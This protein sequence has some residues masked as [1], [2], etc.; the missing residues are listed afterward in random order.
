MLSIPN[1][2]G[3]SGPVKCSAYMCLPGGMGSHIPRQGHAEHPARKVTP[4]K[5]PTATG[6]LQCS[7]SRG[8]PNLHLYPHQ[9]ICIVESSK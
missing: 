7:L 8:E 6:P 5:C 9:G 1:L 3:S 4:N 2:V